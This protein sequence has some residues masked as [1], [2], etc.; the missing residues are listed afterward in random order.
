MPATDLHELNQRYV[1]AADRCRSQWTF[2]QFLQGVF[3]HLR[4]TPCPVEIDY[5]ALF[6]ELRA[7]AER[8]GHPDNA[9]TV[10]EITRLSIRLDSQARQLHEI[11]AGIAPSLLRRFFDRLRNQDEKVILAIIKF[12]LDQI[13][14]N[15][16]SLDKIDILLTRLVEIPREDGDSLT[17]EPH[18]IERIIQPLLQARPLVATPANE[19][20]ILLH[21]LADIKTEVLA[22]RRFT[23]L[24]AGGALDRFRTLKRR[25][26]ENILHARLLPA[27]LETTIAIKNRFRELW[28]EEE[29]NILDD[30]NRVR[31]IQ[32]QF[33]ANPD[34]ATPELREALDLFDTAH[35]RF[36]HGRQEET[37]RRD[38]AL[39]LRLSLNRILETFDAV[40]TMRPLAAPPPDES[41]DELLEGDAVAFAAQQRVTLP[42][43]AD[44]LLQEYVSKIVFALELIGRDRAPAEIVRARELATL[45]LEP[46]E[47]EACL[48]VVDGVAVSGSLDGE[49]AR[50]LLLAA[51]LRIRMDE[52]AREIDRLQRL[53]SDH[54]PDLLE[55]ASQ[56][57]QRAADVERRFAWFVDDA[58]YRGETDN[59]EAIYRSRFRLMRAYSGLWLIHNERGGISPF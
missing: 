42:V 56:S 52:E 54:L 22:C 32:R 16:D 36:E 2:Y 3:K 58:L 37:L 15:E 19:I 9:G 40:E 43:G 12:Y 57:L 7:L 26:G 8:I 13:S 14:L 18:E 1:R 4:A 41:T 21:A 29:V 39:E 10:A 44:P 24:V 50:H 30:T 59:L 38:D 23:E 33:D 49:R 27:V 53:G 11:D 47:V 31:E 45:R 35:R 34:I 5:P 28:R 48:K 51:A 6:G 20:D 17:K 46:W 25:L 55:R